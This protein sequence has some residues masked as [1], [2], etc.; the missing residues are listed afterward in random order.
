MKYWEKS[1]LSED[2]AG[3]AEKA[4]FPEETL[5]AAWESG[6]KK[7]LDKRLHYDYNTIVYE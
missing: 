4:N 3:T 5:C 2:L 1:I 7:I 6:I